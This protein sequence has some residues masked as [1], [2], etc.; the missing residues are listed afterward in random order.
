MVSLATESWVIMMVADNSVCT[1]TPGGGNAAVNNR[2][3]DP[4]RN[5]YVAPQR[6]R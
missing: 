2:I 3:Y 6:P 5:A 1:V 4:A